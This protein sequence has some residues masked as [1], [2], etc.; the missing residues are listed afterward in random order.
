MCKLQWTKYLLLQIFNIKK[1]SAIPVSC[2]S[3][4]ISFSILQAG[5][6]GSKT[7]SNIF[8]K[9]VF[10]KALSIAKIQC[11]RLYWSLECCPPIT[12]KQDTI[13]LDYCLPS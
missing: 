9:L 5:H 13:Y 2:K 10:E 12:K 11:N 7:K 8:V 3:P 4:S 6:L 1:H